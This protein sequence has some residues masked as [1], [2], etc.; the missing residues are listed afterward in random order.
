MTDIGAGPATGG[1]SVADFEIWDALARH[2]RDRPTAMA[3]ADGD[4][5]FD[6]HAVFD[7]LR[8]ARTSAADLGIGPGDTTLV[9]CRG[10]ARPTIL[11]LAIE[12][13]GATT[14]CF[15]GNLERSGFGVL[16]SQAKFLLHDDPFD[17]ETDIPRRR[18]D[19]AWWDGVARATPASDE[20]PAL[21]TDRARRIISS[22]GTTGRPKLIATTHAQ[23]ARRVETI[24][25]NFGYTK[26]AR[27]FTSI[28]LTFQG[29]ILH[30]LACLEAGGCC[31]FDDSAPIWESL[32]RRAATHAGLLPAQLATLNAG[33]TLPPGMTFGIYGAR[34]STEARSA[35]RLASPGCRLVETYA[36]NE[37]ASVSLL[38]PDGVGTLLPG[39]TAEIVDDADTVL[40]HGVEGIIRVRRPGMSTEYLNDA[41]A[42][43][44]RFRDGWF[45]PGDLGV[46]PDARHLRVVARADNVLNIEG[47]KLNADDQEARVRR[48]PGI[49]DACFLARPDSTGAT[50][51]WLGIVLADGATMETVFPIV[52]TALKP[53]MLPFS[54]FQL[55]AVPRTESGKAMR[56]EI[57]K[58]LE[59]A[60]V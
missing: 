23:N 44:D 11:T 8:R 20:T 18:I 54:V 56:R 50:R 5:S 39:A 46:M 38:D 2:A 9:R 10:L 24:Q 47:L 43:L 33:T 40:P 52:D 51:L 3:L 37:V 59:K 14:A 21:P 25:A 30:M 55:K 15:S 28:G 27:F 45:Y 7:L 31:L 36:T 12:S 32:P 41:A 22:S 16:A 60:G 48:I 42:T 1:V 58:S 17:E 53:L 49:A 19:G 29:T 35:L 4:V 13:L 57:V 6:Y 34:L 26:D